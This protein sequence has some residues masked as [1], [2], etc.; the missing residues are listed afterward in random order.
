MPLPDTIPM[1]HDD[2]RLDTIGTHAGGQFYA[3]IHGA[4]HD[5]VAA[6][7]DTWWYAFVHLFD[8]TGHRV[9]SDIT[10][11]AQASYLRGELG[12]QARAALASLLAK[13]TDV[14]H[15]DIAIRPFE[16]THDGVTFAL[17]DETDADPDRGPW[18]ELYPDRLGFGPPFDGTY[19]T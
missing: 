3:A 19:S 18:A 10:T 17:I 12:D 4:R 11:V 14:R 9:R 6:R 15:G 5:S 7:E 16:L 13:L 2:H 8:A 1:A